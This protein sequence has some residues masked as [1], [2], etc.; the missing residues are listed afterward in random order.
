MR[1][2]LGV[3]VDA[4][5]FFAELFEGA[6]EDVVDEE[7][8]VVAA[9]AE[10]GEFDDGALDAEVEVF[11][12][13]FVADGVEE[14]FV[15]GGEEAD[16]DFDGVVGAEAGDF[17]VLQDAEEFGLHGEGHVADFV[18]EEGAAVGVFE[19]ALAV[20]AGVGEGSADVA[21]EFVFEGGF[22][23]AGAVEGDEAFGAAAGVLVEGAGDEFLAG[24]GFAEDE[25]VDIGGGDLGDE[26]EDA[27]DGGGLADD[28]VDAEALV[29]CVGE[30]A[31]SC[32]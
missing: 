3:G 32:G 28:A 14:I 10:R 29:E 26:L 19:A 30:F 15:G 9:V 13:G 17:A 27:L 2:L 1:E 23:E 31:S 7:R 20:A 6:G 24:A 21:E 8:D 18:E 16:V 4:I 22:V 5:D 25:D 11:A 12:E